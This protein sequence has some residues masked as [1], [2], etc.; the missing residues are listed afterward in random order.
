MGEVS[1]T[2]V[3]IFGHEYKIKGYADKTYIEEIARYVHDKMKEVAES[4][5]LT[6]QERVAVLA[7]LNI[8]DE[9][10]QENKKRTETFSSVEERAQEMLSLLDDG[11]LTEK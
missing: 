10:F 9:L 4:T 6:S 2:S 5:A 8:A 7:A 1:V 3:H 11:L